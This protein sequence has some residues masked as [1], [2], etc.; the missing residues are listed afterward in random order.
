MKLPST[1]RPSY[2]RSQTNDSFSKSPVGLASHLTTMRFPSCLPCLAATPMTVAIRSVE[3]LAL[4][5]TRRLRAGFVAAPVSGGPTGTGRFAITFQVSR[6]AV[7]A[8][9]ATL[10]CFCGWS[11]Q[12]AGSSVWQLAYKSV[13]LTAAAGSSRVLFPPQ[14]RQ[15]PTRDSSDSSRAGWIAIRYLPRRR[16]MRLHDSLLLVALLF[17]AG[18]NTQTG[19][20]PTE[21]VISK[22]SDRDFGFA[23]TWI[24]TPDPVF[25]DEARTSEMSI[26]RAG[27]Y[28]V[29]VKDA[30][31]K[32]YDRFRIHF[33]AHEISKE[34]P[35]AVV[36]I[37]VKND[38]AVTCRRLAIAE[39][40]N[41][42]L[43]LW[44]IDAR[45]LGDHL[46]DDGVAAVIEH[47]TFSSTVRCDPQKLLECV[48]KHSEDVVGD[49]QV[50]R[51]KPTNRK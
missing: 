10:V 8:S 45:K 50:F 13:M 7:G 46:Y 33:R 49:V 29:A 51:R 47:F 11:Q 14:K 16:K 2:L 26:E 37:E 25:R 36:E 32:S 21:A 35:R 42:H 6:F 12:G 31:G 28:A 22:C 27:S 5:L 44:M 30:S 15:F 3:Q 39:V 38:G 24:S 4:N 41:D 40:K 43:Y 48:V 34:Q 23:G 9:W 1:W 18:C 17:A 19:V 20:A